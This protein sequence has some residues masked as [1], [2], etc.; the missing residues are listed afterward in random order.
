M[1]MIDQCPGHPR[2]TQLHYLSAQAFSQLLGRL[3]I[4]QLGFLARR[5]KGHVDYRPRQVAALGHPSGMAH[6]PLG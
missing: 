1:G 2:P 3:E 5:T 4:T 6:Q